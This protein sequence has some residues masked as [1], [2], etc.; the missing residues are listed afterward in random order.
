MIK[1]L[2]IIDPDVSFE[3]EEIIN[4]DYSGV[5][6]KKEQDSTLLIY[7]LLADG[8]IKVFGKDFDF[9][10]EKYNQ[11]LNQWFGSL[12]YN[13]TPVF[14]GLGG[15]SEGSLIYSFDSDDFDIES[16][17]M[18]ISIVGKDKYYELA[19]NFDKKV[20]V[21]DYDLP[22]KSI[23]INTTPRKLTFYDTEVNQ[24]SIWFQG[25]LNNPDLNP[26]AIERTIYAREEITAPSQSDIFVLEGINGW[27]LQS[28]KLIRDWT[29]SFEPPTVAPHFY[30]VT[31]LYGFNLQGEFSIDT[32][33][34]PYTIRDFTPTNDFL[35]AETTL[36]GLFFLS[37][38]GTS[39]Y[40]CFAF[41]NSDYYRD[42]KFKLVENGMPLFSLIKAISND[43]D[44]QIFNVGFDFEPFG[45]D[46]SLYIQGITELSRAKRLNE[47]PQ[48]NP[49]TKGFITLSEINRMLREYFN[50]YF[51]RFSK[52]NNNIRYCHYSRLYDDFTEI[53]DL[54]NTRF[55]DLTPVEVVNYNRQK[56][57]KRLE[58]EVT[59]DNVDFIGLDLEFP[60]ILT[61][62]IKTANMSKFFFDVNDILLNQEKYSSFSTDSWAL[63]LKESN[64]NLCKEDPQILSNRY[65]KFPNERLSVAWIDKHLAVGSGS[66]A[67]VNGVYKTLTDVFKFTEL[68][69]FEVP[70]DFF[71]EANER[72]YF[73]TQYSDKHI[74]KSMELKLDGSPC[75]ITLFN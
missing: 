50:I 49:Q 74:L 42:S 14:K 20:N 59:A 68:I 33:I 23:Q 8:E 37:S 34:P 75:E 47:T 25:F 48:I 73:K 36:G 71:F 58:R 9:F 15:Q 28:G 41:N 63:I 67:I 35:S 69:K 61:D 64:R 51:F 29:Y 21:Y 55:G 3:M 53:N 31:D 43:L 45:D 39:Y 52:T 22:K 2:R 12:E 19:R 27:V 44:N 56:K 66:A 4:I 6:L 38:G 10:F 46:V 70:I 65:D 57:W 1:F 17:V 72:A 16:R 7:R 62:N 60:R 26:T 24:S 30:I 18:T 40:Y 5:T 11:G 13:G 32:V 54:T